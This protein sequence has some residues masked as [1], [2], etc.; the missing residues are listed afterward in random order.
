MISQNQHPSDP[1]LPYDFPGTLFIHNV[2]NKDTLTIPDFLPSSDRIGHP[3]LPEYL[4]SHIPMLLATALK[5]TGFHHDPPDYE[6]RLDPEA[7]AITGNI[8]FQV[9]HKWLMSLYGFFSIPPEGARLRK[10]R[11]QDGKSH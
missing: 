8:S 4:P 11:L 5:W 9:Y 6:C 10:Q 1:I 3:D 2:L 7:H